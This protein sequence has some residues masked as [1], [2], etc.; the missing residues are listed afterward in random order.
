MAAVLIS[1]TCTALRRV[2]V[3]TAL[4]LS[5]MPGSSLAFSKAIWGPPYQNGVNQFP[6]YHKLGVSIDEADLYWNVV[7]PTRPRDP[8]NPDDPAYQWPLGIQQAIDQA[9]SFHMRVMIQIIFTPRWANGGRPPNWA[10]S[11][12]ADFAAFATAAA[13][14]YPSVH[15]W[16]V[17]GEP[18]GHASF[19]PI[20]RALPGRRLNRAQQGAPHRYAR[21]LDATFAALKRVSRRNLVIGGCTYT[22]GDIDTQQWIEN[23]RLPNGRAPRMDMYA[24]NPF[25]YTDPSFSA[26][27]SPFGLVQFSDLP[28]MARWIDRYLHRG[29]PIFLSEWTIATHPDLEFDFWVDPPVAARWIRDALRLARR[30]KRIYALGWVHVYDDPPYTYGGLLYANGKPKPGFEA[31]ARG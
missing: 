19:E 2:G 11:N 12:P 3:L 5:V 23:L 21:L 18:N 8:A 22:A 29:L 4:L 17:W 31:F 14:R 13:R 20:S 9:R 28:R 10:P 16:M 6:L 1:T 26:R 25:S 7:A 30:W 27:P 24:H 15:L